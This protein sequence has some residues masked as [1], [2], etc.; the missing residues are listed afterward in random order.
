MTDNELQHLLKA[1]PEKGQRAFYDK[2]FNYVYTIVFAKLKSVAS[3]E[4]VDECVGDVF[5]LCFIFFDKQDVIQGNLNGS[6]SDDDIM[7]ALQTF[8]DTCISYVD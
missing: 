5:A 2:Y 3:I 6:S 1:E 8:Q 7:K 4:D